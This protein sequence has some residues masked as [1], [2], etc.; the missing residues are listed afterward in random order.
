MSPAYFEKYLD[1]APFSLA[2][3][4]AIE[5]SA[6]H[7]AKRHTHYHRPILDL[8]CGFGEFAGV[9]FKS[10]IEVGI[11]IS[12]TDLLRAA[13]GKKYQ[14]LYI[15]DARHLSFPNDSFATVISISVL[16]HIPRVNPAILEAYRVLRPGGFFIITL[17]T[18]KLYPY[19]F[20]PQLFERIGLVWLARWYYRLYNQAFKHVNLWP[21]AK[22][23]KLVRAAG[24]EVVY[25]Q[26]IISPAATKIFDLFL[27]TA[28]PSQ[29]GRWL[30][31]NRLIWGLG[32]KKKLLGAIF[33]PLIR[34]TTTRGSNII[35][36]AQKPA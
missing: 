9:F 12:A 3:W 15:Q 17:P 33:N 30:L 26:E 29:I 11:D 27:L 1:I 28:L 18:N 7:Q 4:R 21:Q 5:A 25:T 19:L 35:L 13:Q 14:N 31:G 10:N 6:L 36:V 16:E 22:W 2:L 23:K 20:Y 24:F 32:W 8:G 34:Q